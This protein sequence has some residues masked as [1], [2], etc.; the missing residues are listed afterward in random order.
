M[1]LGG[2]C[3]PTQHVCIG[4][5]GVTFTTLLPAGADRCFTIFSGAVVSK[6]LHTYTHAALCVMFLLFLNK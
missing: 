3:A 5:V 4:F 1:L 6:H 2:V